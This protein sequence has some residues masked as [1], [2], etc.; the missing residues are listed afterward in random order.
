MEGA[1][2][3]VCVKALRASGTPALWHRRDC[4]RVAL[5]DLVCIHH[6][7]YNKIHACTHAHKQQ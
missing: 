3:E 7:N 2:G 6:N 4:A 1:A 5:T